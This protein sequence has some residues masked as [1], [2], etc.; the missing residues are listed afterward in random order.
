MG[1]TQH[2][3]VDFCSVHLYIWLT[4][5]RQQGLREKILGVKIAIN[6]Q[7]KTKGAETVGANFVN[8]KNAVVKMQICR[9]PTWLLLILM[10]FRQFVQL[11][12]DYYCCILSPLCDTEIGM[13]G[14]LLSPKHFVSPFCAD[15]SEIEIKGNKFYFQPILDSKQFISVIFLFLT[16]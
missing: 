2:V 9:C 15:I 6:C 11:V 4:E 1:C 5:K 8:R 12:V 14:A 16:G 3:T 10:N 13:P 7:W